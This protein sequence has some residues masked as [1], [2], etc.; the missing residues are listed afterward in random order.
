M[1]GKGYPFVVYT[2]ALVVVGII[3]LC[4]IDTNWGKVRQ[5]GKVVGY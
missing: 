2:H 4:A 5:K 3:C 1:A